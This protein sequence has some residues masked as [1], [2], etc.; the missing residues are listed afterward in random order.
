MKKVGDVDRDEPLFEI[1]T[2]KVDAE[3]PSPAAGVLAEISV[4]EGETVPSTVSS[5]TIRSAG[6]QVT[7]PPPRHPPGGHRRSHRRKSRTGG[8]PPA[9]RTAP[10][11]RR[12]VQRRGRIASCETNSAALTRSIC[13]PRGGPGVGAGSR[14]RTNSDFSRSGLRAPRSG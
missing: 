6:G 11:R 5:A 10:G 1:S 3:I 14:R 9:G 8:R 4:T 2:D 13:G 7:H 12:S